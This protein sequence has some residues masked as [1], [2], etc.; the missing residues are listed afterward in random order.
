MPDSSLSKKVEALE[1]EV[2]QLRHS[3]L[4]LAQRAKTLGA[5]AQK[6]HALT[7][8]Q[9]KT[10][11]SE[12]QKKIQNIVEILTLKDFRAQLETKLEKKNLEL[13]RL[14]ES[15][16]SATTASEDLQK[17]NSETMQVIKSLE[18]KCDKFKEYIFNV[19]EELEGA[20][21]QVNELTKRCRQL[22]LWNE[23]LKFR[24]DLLDF[25]NLFMNVN[26]ELK[27][28]V[29]EYRTQIRELIPILRTL[30]RENRVLE[31]AL[32]T[33]F[34]LVPTVKDL[35]TIKNLLK[36]SYGYIHDRRVH[37]ELRGLLS[38]V[39]V[40]L[41][42]LEAN[43]DE[44]GED[45]TSSQTSDTANATESQTPNMEREER[46]LAKVNFDSLHTLINTGKPG[47]AD[48]GNEGICRDTLLKNL[49]LMRHT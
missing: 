33:S 13:V 12:K 27:A 17:L 1:L 32:R 39:G 5:Q 19:E 16:N 48:A 30:V 18:V 41:D 6:F 4:Q 43:V 49:E 36:R 23:E 34:K 46:R 15:L 25:G 44:G 9:N 45:G 8:E 35:T 31:L 40:D 21:G 22:E 2:Q 11:D 47:A 37:K 14:Q 20:C 29:K 28:E 26:R 7:V 38:G 10:L 3:E 42:K 24:V